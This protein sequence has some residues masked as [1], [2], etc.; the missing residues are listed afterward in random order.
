MDKAWKAKWGMD[1]S[2]YGL[3]PINVFHKERTEAVPIIEHKPELKNYHMLVR[4]K[5]VING[6]GEKSFLDITADDYYKLY[7]NGQYIGQGP[8]PSYY[9][10]YGYNRYDVSNYLHSG[11][12]IIAVHVY[13]QGLLNRV[14]NSADYR[15]GLIAELLIDNEI[16]LYTDKTWKYTRA[17]EF[18]SN[19]TVGYETQFRED[20][21]SRLAEKNWRELDYDDSKW[22]SLYVNLSDDHKL[23]LQNTPVLEVYEK[24]PETVK[25]IEKGHY[26][27]D[28]GH[29]ITGQFK[30]EAYGEPGQS[31][32]ILCGEELDTAQEKVRYNMRCNCTYE[33]TW[34]LSGARDI[35]EFYDYKAFRYVEVISPEG[36]LI[37]ES[38]CAIVRHYPMK[39][40][41]C[42][43][44]SSNE[45]LNS[46]WYICK[47]GVKY[48]AQEVFVDCPSREKGQYL[49]DATVTSHSH[50]YLSGDLRLFKKSLKDFAL[51]TYICP[52][53]MAVAPGSFMQE[54]ADFSLQWPY[55]LLN[56]FMHSNDM[57]FLKEMY[58]IAEGVITYFKQYQ[59]EDG[60]IENVRDKWN[61]VDWPDNLRDNYDFELTQPIGEGCHNV[62]NAFFC[63]AVKTLNEIKKVLA[64][65]FD[66][67]FERLKEAYVNAFYDK[68]RKLFRDSTV[69]Y[70]TSLHSN[71]L[72]LFW[73][74]VPQEAQ[75][76]VIELI[77]EK[78]L[79]CG[80]YNAYFLLKGL[81]KADAYELVYEL[82]TSKE[83]HSWANMLKE[84]AT[85]CFEAWGK[86]QKWNTSLCH[87]WAS[88]PISVIIEDIIGIRPA[89]P[90]WEEVAFTP[91]IPKALDYLCIE[92][93]T[94]KG[95]IKMEY[96]DGIPQI[97]IP[98][99]CKL[100]QE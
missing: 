45:L 43:F 13:Y 79:N 20:I 67:E 84:G 36:V 71:M 59:R 12:N 38:L 31:I 11:E 23:V 22:Q 18:T 85:T 70:H 49:G 6:I 60:L 39:E 81:A 82:L 94:I 63:G 27:I 46:I 41:D 77:R 98:P 3:T 87:P 42:K 14:W 34:T 1:K 78:R 50:V 75:N 8:A 9:F 86:E 90:G 80:V 21:D 89:K 47:N 5:F 53:I 29:E 69:S 55:Q 91:H 2:F 10:N 4:K 65:D 37:P 83:E 100:A 33:D 96:K 74:L 76:N 16:V 73:G 52:G 62:L 92:F 97:L 32:T 40:K 57:E 72:P 30:A 19:T 95:R 61:L 17:L 24:K 58:P 15:Q 68:E 44:V 28:F 54:I 93:E 66:D 99:S 88:A 64:I 35:L 26:L 51:S 7:I 25:Q 48:G 56:Y